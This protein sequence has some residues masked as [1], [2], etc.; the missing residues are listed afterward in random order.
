MR[1]E[2]TRL[3]A[4]RSTGWVL[5]LGLS[6]VAG[7]LAQ[8]TPSTMTVEDYH[9]RSTLVVPEHRLTRARFPVV[10]VHGHQTQLQTDADVDSLVAAMDRLN[11]RAM[12]NLSGG[13]GERLARTVDLMTRR[14]PGRFVVFANIDFRGVGSPGW[15]ERTVAQFQRDVQVG[16]AR[17]LKIFKNL[18]LDATDVNGA[19]IPVDD[20]RLDPIWEKCA[21]LGVPVMIHSGE[22]QPLFDPMDQFNERWLELKVH[23]E[24]ARPAGRYPPFE[25]I[26]AEQRNMF[27]KHP[28]T[29]FIAAHLAWRG[30]DLAKLGALLDSLPNV[31]TEV[32][33]VAH[34][35]GRQPRAARAFMI[36]YQDRV[37]M[38][39]DTWAEAEY[40]AYFRI[41]ETADEYFDWIRP[42]AGGWK[43][44]GL[45][46]PDSVLRKVYLENPLRVYPGLTADSNR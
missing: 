13:S 44:Y 35:L 34:E 16:G 43:L 27:R 10:D 3:F 32:A 26:M 24:R 38:G 31:Y 30:N 36:K 15:T 21:E 33:A 8:Q 11:M 25:Q 5:L 42:Y 2:T 7:L 4:M 28:R 19:R 40:G 39:K 45:E 9:P 46:L 18:G 22:P 37:M 17:G 6:P 29:T 1:L 41:F 20:P 23:P 14:H 12:V